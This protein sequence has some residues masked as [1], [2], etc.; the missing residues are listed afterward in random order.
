MPPIE[1]PI[2]AEQLVD[3]EMVD[4]HRLRAHHVA[5][6]DDRQV[7]PVGLAG[8]RIGRGGAGRAQ[9]AADDVGADDEEAVGVDD[10]AGPDQHFPPAGLAGDR[11]GVGDMLVAGQRMADQHGVGLR[12]VQRAVGLVGDLERRQQHAGVELQR[13]VGAEAQHRAGRLVGLV[14]V[15]SGARRGHRSILIC[16]GS[17]Q[18]TKNRHC[19]RKAGHH[20]NGPLATCLTWL[21]AD[22]P[23]HHGTVLHLRRAA[24]CVN[25]KALLEPVRHSELRAFP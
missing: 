22:R 14:G 11:V 15:C 9:A 23:N 25:G 17:L 8:R 2:T 24:L 7:E 19:A 20:A 1:P 12:R 16:A 10:L 4:Q 18:A 13:P 21:Q 3:A 6:G 5:D